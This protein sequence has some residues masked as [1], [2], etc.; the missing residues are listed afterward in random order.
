MK[1][2]QIKLELHKGIHEELFENAS[3]AIYRSALDLS[4]LL[5]FNNNLMEIL[6]YSREELQMMSTLD[7]RVIFEEINVNNEGKILERL[8]NEL[9]ESNPQLSELKYIEITKNTKDVMTGGNLN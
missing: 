8:N 5:Y 1:S 3:V 7:V 4:E 2:N 6:G 9:G